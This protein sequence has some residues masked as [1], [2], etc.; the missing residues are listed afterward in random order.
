MINP[1][2]NINWASVQFVPS[3]S[4]AHCKWQ[5][6]FD[7]LVNGGLRHLA[8]SNYHP[9]EP[10]YPLADFFTVPAGIIGSPNTE[11]SSMQVGSL[12]INGLGS[13]YS[14]PEPAPS[15]S[16]KY[17]V[18]QILK[19]LQFADAGGV[20]INHPTW[21]VETS[22]ELTKTVILEMLDYDPLVL[23][24]E[25]YNALAYDFPES[26]RWALSLWDDVLMTGRRCW[27][28]CVSDH[29]GERTDGLPW[30]GRNV[31]LVDEFTEHDCLKAYREGKFYGSIYN[32]SL[33]FTNISLNGSTLSV[34]ATDAEYINFVVN[35]AI[36]RIDAATA[37]FT[38][39]S[40]AVYVRI[41][42]HNSENSIFSNP[43]IFKP[44]GYRK[45]EDEDLLLLF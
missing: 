9:S 26:Q 28:F 31:L 1:Y 41:E 5:E 25:Y 39:P 12:H 17:K 14:E 23:G 43:I 15:K 7:Q 37:S 8:L 29:D 35:G 21:S 13:F 3:C 42:A 2:E 38:I 34:S 11:F 22:G 36:T 24:I 32:T 16:W 19:N 6:R 18:T 4:H 40:S 33:K 20:T 27:G 44:Y 30:R 45:H 10:W